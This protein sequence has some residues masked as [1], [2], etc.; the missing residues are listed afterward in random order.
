MSATA[1]LTAREQESFDRMTLTASPRVCR[2]GQ[3]TSNQAKY[4]RG[5]LET[6]EL[7]IRAQLGNPPRRRHQPVVL[8]AQFREADPAGNRGW[9][10]LKG[11]VAQVRYPRRASLQKPCRTA[12]AELP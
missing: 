10:H 8:G 4:Q 2:G 7:L 9:Q 1:A 5:N 11:V 12:C 6:N 3:Y